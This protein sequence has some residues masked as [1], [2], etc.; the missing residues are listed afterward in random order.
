[1]SPPGSPI[2]S[3]RDLTIRF[4]GIVAL[5]SVGFDVA[6]GEIVWVRPDGVK[7]FPRAQLA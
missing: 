7:E 4:G 6:E 1:M 3:V 2:L 5:D